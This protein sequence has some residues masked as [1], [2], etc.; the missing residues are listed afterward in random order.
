MAALV[1]TRIDRVIVHPGAAQITRTGEVAIAA[2]QELRLAGLPVALDD[3]SVQIA[4]AGPARAIDLRVAVD[5]AIPG[6][7]SALLAEVQAA[8]RAAAA[9][10]AE[11]A[12]VSQALDSLGWLAP[13][14]PDERD[15]AR[16]AWSDAVVARLRVLEVGRERGVALRAALA[17]LDR[18][19][20][21]ARRA[22]AAAEARYARRSSSELPAGAVTKAIVVT[23]EPDG[24]GGACALS[25]SYRVGGARWAPTYVARLDDG[26]VRLELRA[27]IAQATGE[28]WS[29][30]A[31]ELSTAS[32]ARRLAL[33]ELAA[34]RI[35]RAQPRPARAGWRSPPVGVEE[36]YR[37]WDRAFAHV[38]PPPPSA[39]P[40]PRPEP[41]AAPRD[42]LRRQAEEAPE[43]AIAAPLPLGLMSPQ[44]GGSGAPPAPPMQAAAPAMME[45]RAAAP[46]KSMSFALGG[47]P[48][49]GRSRAPAPGAP[50][51]AAASAEPPPPE[52][53]GDAPIAAR[54]ELLAFGELVLAGPRQS[55]R[56]TLVRER[57]E[58]RWATAPAI[59]QEVRR[60]G[61]AAARRVSNLSLPAGLRAPEPGVYD[62]AFASD[63]RLDVPGDGAW[64]QVA[65][66][67]HAAPV[68]IAHVVTPAVAPDVYRVA[69]LTNPLD[70][71]LLAGPVDVYERGE[72]VI[73][74]QLDETPPGGAVAIGL[75]V[76]PQVKTARNARY[77]EET[78]GVLR[79]SLRLV[80]DVAVDVENLG[81]QAIALEVR[82][83][84]P[85]PAPD[86][87]DIEIAIERVAPM[88]DPWRPEPRAG[89]PPLRG[90]HRWQVAVG[91]GEKKQLRVEYAIK[92]AGK[93]E[94]VGGNRRE[95]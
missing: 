95:P 20:D 8:R 94:L 73:T 85:I 87:D 22:L 46:K 14:E 24:A 80:H 41:K 64:H 34:L 10:A 45:A 79:G 86:T 55:G 89:D 26:Q 71:P 82:E 58:K 36:L 47:P 48:R 63:G 70:A 76:D 35:G 21:E 6:E 33:P 65:V 38:T 93:H 62:Y 42:E 11:H 31:I 57:D 81:A 50:A 68:A 5:A 78:A 29:Q 52:D 77:R 25:C 60:T 17:E 66:A 74:A 51:A 30:V 92:I 32:P 2:R 37:D 7:P 4:V 59:A 88:W 90:G 27:A 84:V 91:P 9:I 23:V 15:G 43:G 72:L 83:R 69:T 19:G 18:A 53:D 75:G 13:V 67:A 1:D 3:D 12:A 16:P 61:P 28:D 54:D 44:A 56:G 39:P 40:K 49:G